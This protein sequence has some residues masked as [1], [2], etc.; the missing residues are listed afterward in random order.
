MNNKFE[1]SPSLNKLCFEQYYCLPYIYFKV[2]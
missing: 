2:V 1:N